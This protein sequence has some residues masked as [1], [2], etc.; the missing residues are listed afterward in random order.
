MACEQPVSTPSITEFAPAKINLSLHVGL[1]QAD[2]FHPIDSQVAFADF[3]DRLYFQS[4]SNI[5]LKLRG[6]FAECVPTG[7]GNLVI[8]AARLL[9]QTTGISEPGVRITLEKTMPVASGIGGGSA[10]A[11]ATLR[12]LNQLWKLAL[13]LPELANIG[14]KLGSDIPA[15]VYASDL[16]MRGRGEQIEL[17]PPCPSKIGV[18]VNPGIQLSTGA[19]F[20]KFDQLA[21]EKTDARKQN[22]LTNAAIQL[23]PEI[24]DLLAVLNQLDPLQPAQMCGSGATCLAFFADRKSAE[25]VAK[26]LLQLHPRWWVQPVKIGLQSVD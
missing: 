16:R 22:S 24:G 25:Q 18:L 14:A 1:K 19:V 5:C 13:P 8:K 3:G 7:E 2:G 23:A 10:D 6:P 26:D 21:P 9:A 4:A 15:C 17:L 12:G 11:A 20:A